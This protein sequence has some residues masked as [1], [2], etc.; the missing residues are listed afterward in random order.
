MALRRTI[1]PALIIACLMLGTAAALADTGPERI[2]SFHSLIRIGTDAAVTVTE[3]I[4]VNCRGEQIKRGIIREFPTTYRDRLGRRV[5]VRFDLQQV[6]REGRP[7][8]YALERST[9]GT[10]VRIG[11]ADVFLEPGDHVY[12]LTYVT[13]RQLGHFDGF[14][15][16]YWNVTGSGWQLPIERA[17]AV[18]ELP[19]GAG[20]RDTAGYTGPEGAT[21]GD[22]RVDRSVEGA[23]TFT[24]TR[25]LKPYEGLTVAVSWPE[26]FVDRPTRGERLGIM[27]RDNAATIAGTA[28]FAFLL[29]YFAAA[30]L[31]VGRDPAR[32]TVIP[33]YEPPGGLSPAAMRFVHRMGFDHKTFAAAVVSLAVKGKL[34]I[35]EEAK[36]YTLRRVTGAGTTGLSRGEKKVLGKLFAGRSSVTL[37]QKNHKAIKGAID[38]LKKSLRDECEKVYFVVNRAFFFPGLAFSLLALLTIVLMPPIQPGAPFLAVWL[39]MWTFGCFFLLLRAWRGVRDAIT[40]QEGRVGAVARALVAGAFVLPFLGGE[41]LGLTLFAR[42]LSPAAFAAAAAILLLVI[43]FYQLLKAP[44]PIGRKVMDRI[45]GFRLFLTVAEKERLALLH[46]PEQTPELFERY[47]A[48][49][50]ALD[51]EQQWGDQFEGT[52]AAAGTD[53]S[54]SWS[55]TWYSGRGW[56]GVDVSGFSSG[57]GRGFSGAIAS[58]SSA[59]GSSS[60]SSGGGSS[61]GGGGGGG[62]GGW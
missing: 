38:A 42:A 41:I 51:V 44:T 34:T 5:T 55:P 60:G 1:L 14:D 2:T 52:L 8:P 6:L 32:G 4:A 40:R 45:E 57:L 26:G 35:S 48:H 19:P 29:L 21:G 3:T 62:G 28:W 54:Q 23:V 7:E 58:S 17:S 39:T 46:P 27:A 25:P 36:Q 24:A 30:W 13:D 33:L 37:K 56:K 11:S 31:A 47:L 12:T 49:A 22:Y 15:E 20:I 10:R 61:G 43:V 50:M 16:L 9:N 18:V 59:P 53:P